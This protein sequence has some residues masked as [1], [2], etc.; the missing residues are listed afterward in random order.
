MQRFDHQSGSHVRPA[1]RTAGVLAALAL[2]LA[3]D[4]CAKHDAVLARVGSRVIT[5]ED[6]D[7][8]AISNAAQYAD[9]PERAK[10]RLLDDMIKRELL[11]V[12]ADRR[13]LSTNTLTGNYRRNIEEQVLAGA[14]MTQVAPRSVPV[15]E[16]EIE[17][18]YDWSQIS[19]HLQVMYSPDRALIDAAMSKLRAGESF[20]TVA[21]QVNPAG[22]LPPGGDLGNVTVGTMVDPLDDFARTAPVGQLIG[23]V[24][25]AGEG[26]FIAR[27]LTR[28]R[29]PAPASLDIMRGQLVNAIRQRKLRLIAAR[30]YLSLRDQY[31]IAI[32]PDGP[33]ALFSYLNA[34]LMTPNGGAPQPAK[35]GAVLARY[36]DA[37]G[38]PLTYTLGDAIADMR[39]TDR[40]RPDASGTP[41]LRLWIGQQVVQ[42]VVLLEAKRRGLDQDPLVAKRINASV[43][44]G[45]LETVYGDE[46]A[47][48]VTVTP[49]DVKQVY[50][51]QAQQYPQL[52][53]AHIQA[54]TLADS[55]AAAELTRHGSHTTSLLEA[56]R[57]MGVADRV[58]DQQ[59]KFPNPDPAW[60]SLAPDVLMMANG[61]W[62]GPIPVKGGWRVFEVVE[63]ETRPQDFEQLSESARQSLTQLAT[64][65]KRDQR[66]TFVTDSLRRVTRPFEVNQA[67]LAAIPWPPAGN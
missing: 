39:R 60:Q 15:N 13:G 44:N 53:G 33:Q 23:P 5:R 57:M 47:A 8:A 62:A 26:W 55:A 30:A 2:I 43:E 17:E 24:S 37:G 35:V 64:E 25:G 49:D 45:L 48:A 36:L 19:A 14:L 16:A 29:V 46:V 58:V 65:M 40:E 28:R 51:A 27:V 63:K 66:L 12:V 9:V 56:A 22:L 38:R 7:A 6:F 32:T 11:L 50:A 18:F 52:T 59:V 4:G 10:Q 3:T 1:P 31:Q 54:I 21:D 42:R 61:E 41:A 34:S 67:A 20:A